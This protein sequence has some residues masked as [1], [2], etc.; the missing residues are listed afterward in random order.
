MRTDK[1]TLFR[2]I[3]EIDEKYVSEILEEDASGM[4]VIKSFDAAK[5][6]T[7]A[8]KNKSGVKKFVMYYLPAAAGLLLC[9]LFVKTF[10]MS[11]SSH[12]A[13]D[14]AAT[15]NCEPAPMAVEA[16]SDSASVDAAAEVNTAQYDAAEIN[17]GE[18]DEESAEATKPDMT[19]T[20]GVEDDAMFI[21]GMP[22]PFI[23][24]ETIE[25]ACEISGIE[26]TIPDDFDF[27]FMR[28]YRAVEGK[29]IEVIFVDGGEEVYR[30][31]KGL[32]SEYGEDISGDYN[33][34]DVSS[35]AEVYGCTAELFGNSEDEMMMA[36]W[37]DGTYAYS[38][39]SEVPIPEVSMVGIINMMM[40][41]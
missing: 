7:S 38:I 34:Y 14:S 9:A 1:N 6:A 4:N 8:K 30:I 21:D 36:R 32:V 28:V 27:G 35:E 41:Q 3:G 25:E 15:A 29:M 24:C 33:E 40:Q 5:A 18:C 17:M 22:N 20:V 12:S 11:T 16:T 13:G 19:E 10:M 2:A 23:D 26:L 39:T 31:R 37:N